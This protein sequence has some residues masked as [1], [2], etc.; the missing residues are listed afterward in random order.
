MAAPGFRCLPITNGVR[1]NLTRVPTAR[2]YFQSDSTYSTGF[3]D[4]EITFERTGP[5]RI[6]VRYKHSAF[7]RA[8]STPPRP[9]SGTVANAVPQAGKRLNITNR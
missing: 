3:A 9:Y 8:D 4:V 1:I 2:Q 6:N 5:G 7:N